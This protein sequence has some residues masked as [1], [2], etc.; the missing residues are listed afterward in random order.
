MRVRSIL[1]LSLGAAVAHAEPVASTDPDRTPREARRPPPAIDPLA[2]AP[3]ADQ[4]SGVAVA[5]PRENHR[6]ANTLLALPR[7][8][9]LLLL[10]GPRYAAREVDG[11]LESRS[12]N[13]FGRDVAKRSWRFGATLEW[14]T[15]LGASLGAR[16]GRE[17]ADHTSL[18]GYV[19]MFGPRGQ[20]G[21]LYARLGRYT[22]ARIEPALS[23]DAGRDLTRAYS[24]IGTLGPRATYDQRGYATAGELAAHAGPVR[25]AARGSYDD[26][27]AGDPSDEFT[28]DPMFF[29][30]DEGTRATTGELSVTLDTRRPAHRHIVRSAPSSG[31]YVRGAAAYTAGVASRSG[32]FTF[33]RGTLE[34][35]RLFDLFGGNRVLSV[36]AGIEAISAEATDVP[37]DRLPALG[38]RDHLRAFAASELRDR[39]AAYADVQYDWPVGNS[40]RSYVFAEVGH[41]ALWH[42]SF[43]GG[44]RY[45][46]KNAVA[47]RIQLAGSD[48]GDLGMFFQLG[49]L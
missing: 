7:M 45:H 32:D 17:L 35:R 29:G 4:A 40:M 47:A 16:V 37:F 9:V 49:A 12:P 42:G 24:G 6:V 8:T 3:P 34:A 48:D 25:F 2:G 21:G 41:T 10:E 26:T 23:F 14:Q 46:T 20:S 33:A 30:F 36:G 18:D 38:G 28:Y 43:G 11:Y 44:L 13:A 39:D 19:G 27:H 5:A 22:A 31:A 1:L 15:A